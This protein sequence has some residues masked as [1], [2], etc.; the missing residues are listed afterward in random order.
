LPYANQQLGPHNKLKQ[1]LKHAYTTTICEGKIWSFEYMKTLMS[2][3]AAYK[4]YCV[5]H[6]YQIAQLWNEMIPGFLA[7]V[8]N[9][10]TKDRL[11]TDEQ[12]ASYF[13]LSNSRRR[14]PA[15]EVVTMEEANIRSASSKR[16]RGAG[17]SRGGPPAQRDGDDNDECGM[18]GTRQNIIGDIKIAA[19]AT[20]LKVTP[21]KKNP[22]KQTPASAK[23]KART[24]ADTRSNAS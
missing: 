5:G 22:A 11:V 3:S 10:D 16:K 7:R 8:K 24:Q 2:A 20:K 21:N 9:F 6:N 4:T 1:C 12:S 17:G 23:K 14:Y 18:G 19:S 13:V 15:K